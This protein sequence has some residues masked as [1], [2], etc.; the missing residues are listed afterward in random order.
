MKKT[1]KLGLVGYGTVGQGVIKILERNKK[2][3]Q[4]RVG[5][6]LEIS[7][8]CDIRPVEIRNIAY[9][10]NFHELTAMS[11]IDIVVELIGGYEPARTLILEALNSGKNVITANKA[12]LAK[13]WDEIFTYARKNSRLVYFEASVAGA[14]PIIQ[15]LNEGLA[16]NKIEKIAGIL[17]GTTNFIL[18]EMSRQN[19]DFK[20]ALRK[21]QKS[22]FA[23]ADSSFDLEGIDTA[24]KLSILSSIAWSGWIKVSDIDVKGISNISRD[25]IFFAKKFG[26]VIKLIGQAVMTPKGLLLSVE[27]C[28]VPLTHTFAN[29]EREYNAVLIHGDSS[30]DIVFY[31][32]GA[33][34]F[35]AASA[36]V[37]D[38]IFLSRQ[39]AS[40]T[41]GKLP[42]VSYNPSKK[43]KILPTDMEESPYYLR[44]SCLDR[45][46]VLSKISGILG[47]YQ[48]SIA[49]V[50]QQEPLTSFRR[51][52]P[53]IILTH[54][55]KKGNLLKAL[56]LI[57]RLAQ[58]R[59]K[60][61]KLK[62]I[63]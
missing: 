28:L 56:N 57:D 8:V 4:Q 61:V 20:T 41:A 51:G 54:R 9:T 43:P 47:K 45:P 6:E 44:F 16:A 49:S 36:V 50:F 14:I 19:V 26:Y 27:P 31:G 22:G 40:G 59:A 35:P 34:Q 17:N 38:I 48:V 37:S 58:T 46:G 52:V 42:Y 39:V 53:I 3:I 12:V 10:K 33:G 1:V 7:A 24:N 21:A 23:E 15:G 30:G 60:T 13:Y 55:S 18:S 63:S 62:I 25:D 11:D 32:R 2:S 5:A 29:V